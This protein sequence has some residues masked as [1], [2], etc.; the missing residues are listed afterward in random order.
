MCDKKSHTRQQADGILYLARN[1]PNR[2]GS[3]KV[4]RK[5]YCH[6][7]AAWHLTSEK[8]QSYHEHIKSYQKKNDEPSKPRN[9]P[10][11]K[12]RTQ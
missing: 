8:K 2:M 5:Y 4:V 1:M 9:L 11:K 7:C 3:K 6:V 12:N 10:K